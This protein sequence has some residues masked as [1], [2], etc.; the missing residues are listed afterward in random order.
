[1]NILLLLLP[2]T[3]KNHVIYVPFNLNYELIVSLALCKAYVVCYSKDPIIV[4]ASKKCVDR[5]FLNEGYVAPNQKLVGGIDYKERLDKLTWPEGIMIKFKSPFYL[6]SMGLPVNNTNY[7]RIEFE[8][9]FEA[10]IFNSQILYD[11]S[12]IGFANALLSDKIIQLQRD[13]REARRRCNLQIFDREVATDKLSFGLHMTYAESY[14]TPIPQS[15]KDKF[16]Y[17][18]VCMKFGGFT[19]PY[20]RCI[21]CENSL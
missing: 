19:K 10:A 5:L 14:H 18:P 21:P 6:A 3:K 16:K 1:M 15:E 9:Y 4:N 2:F 20:F 8:E 12:R 17:C 13:R 11:L 7:I